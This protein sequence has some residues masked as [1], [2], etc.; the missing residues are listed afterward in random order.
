VDLLPGFPSGKIPVILHCFFYSSLLIAACGFIAGL[1]VITGKILF[2]GAGGDRVT[3]L[4]LPSLQINIYLPALLLTPNI[5]CSKSYSITRSD[6]ACCLQ[7]FLM[8]CRLQLL[9][10]QN[11][12]LLSPDF[13]CPL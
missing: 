9:S 2:I 5:S 3:I 13:I 8:L 6:T 1:P 12:D 10:L 11:S 4:K 7:H